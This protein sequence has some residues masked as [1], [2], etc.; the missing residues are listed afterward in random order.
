MAVAWKNREETA[1]ELAILEQVGRRRIKRAGKTR[2]LKIKSW[3][4][5]MNGISLFEPSSKGVCHRN[6]TDGCVSQ[7]EQ[8]ALN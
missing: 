1:F 8:T 7:R 2:L 5:H 6:V 4:W 3:R